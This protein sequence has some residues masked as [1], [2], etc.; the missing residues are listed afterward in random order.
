MDKRDDMKD[1]IK[2]TADIN[3]EIEE[4]KWKL[5]KLYEAKKDIDNWIG[6]PKYDM[7]RL[8]LIPKLKEE[9]I[10]HLRLIKYYNNLLIDK[11]LNYNEDDWYI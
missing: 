4:L 10:E 8:I 1:V 6:K 9:T 5:R 7:M 3:F 11:D 2:I